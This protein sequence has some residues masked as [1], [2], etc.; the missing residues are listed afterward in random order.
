MR[1]VLECRA[2][3]FAN[4][5]RE[6]LKRSI[7]AAEGRT[8]VA[9]VIGA[10]PPWHPLVTNAEIVS[11]FGADLVLLNLFD[12]NRPEVKGLDAEGDATVR[13]LKELIGRPIGINLEP[14]DA[15]AEAMEALSDLPQGRTATAA[16]LERARELGFD[17]VCL[18]GNPKTGVSNRAI[19]DAIGRARRHFGGLVIA[20][21]MH[22]AGVRSDCLTD[23]AT[24]EAFADAG[25]DVVLF[26]APGTVPGL[27]EDA[28][29]Q[30]INAAHAK[31]ALALTAIGTSQEGADRETIREIALAAK[32]AGADLQHIG[33]A[34][35]V[36]GMCDP[37]NLYQLSV[38]IRGRRHTFFRMASSVGR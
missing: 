21:K 7:E 33:D 26:P 12:V 36:G 29:R 9:E 35:T 16:S 2:S 4:A 20:G 8:V 13:R 11:A 25:A 19:L 31:G 5:G 23:T 28:L 34:G 27:G 6:E 24:V 22:A 18:T 30:L 32:R 1:R 15:G 10:F 17:A 14:V 3:D 37:E 38:T